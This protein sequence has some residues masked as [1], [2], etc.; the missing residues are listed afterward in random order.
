MSDFTTLVQ[1]LNSIGNNEQL[2]VT[3]SPETTTKRKEIAETANLL[4]KFNA[5]SAENPYQPVVTEAEDTEVEGTMQDRFAKFLKA[6]RSAGTE[7][8]EMKSLIDEGTA[9][10]EYVDRAFGKIS[11]T[12]LTLEKMVMQ[13]GMLEKKIEQAGGDSEV[14]F[15]MRNAL[16]AAYEA[17]YEAQKDALGNTPEE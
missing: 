17:C 6:E 13:G 5:I 1:K 8:E 9:E 16:Q 11:E 2:D 12:L 10:Y 15:D 3:P 14:L 7:V 4:S